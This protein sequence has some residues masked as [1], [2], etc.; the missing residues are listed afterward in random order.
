[1]RTE[2]AV[3]PPG[4]M[5]MLGLW[6][7]LLVALAAA[8]GA[9]L[10]SS[11]QASARPLWIIVPFIAVI[12]A[13]MTWAAQRRRIAVENRELEITATLYRK[14]VPVEAL[15]LGRARILNLDEHTE[16]R[17]MMK[18]NGFNLPGLAA[19]H[20]RMRNLSKAFC[21]VTDRTRVLSLPM[22][23]G[24]MLLLS[25]EKPRDLLDALRELATPLPRR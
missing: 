15:D 23:E 13:L 16:L 20:Y 10:M 7:P 3:T 5:A 4:R 19:G 25:A 6:M 11:Q 9:A 22:R 17:P 2:Y 14:R 18:T 8:A 21:L 24:P 12:G 1:M